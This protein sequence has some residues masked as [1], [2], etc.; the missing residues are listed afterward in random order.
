[1]SDKAESI[2][3]IADLES[4]ERADK[5]LHELFQE[6]D[7]LTHL[8]RS[9]IQKLI[10][11]GYQRYANEFTKEKSVTAYMEYFLEIAQKENIL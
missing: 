6:T 10:E 5:Y 11:N 1:M 8:S 4:T 9:Q 3:L 2:T 7:G